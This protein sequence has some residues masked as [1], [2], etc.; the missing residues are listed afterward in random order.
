MH[1]L[2]HFHLINA[3]SHYSLPNAPVID[4]TRP[5]NSSK[6]DPSSNANQFKFVNPSILMFLMILMV[7]NQLLVIIFIIKYVVS[8]RKV[9]MMQILLC[10]NDFEPVNTIII[11]F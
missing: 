9:L 8:R 3:S 11:Y 1:H 4:N 2:I 7:L 6:N 10:R 5:F